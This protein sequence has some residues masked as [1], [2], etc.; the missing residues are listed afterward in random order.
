MGV[1]ETH[2]FGEVALGEFQGRELGAYAIGDL[3]RVREVQ[4]QS[5]TVVSDRG[6]AVAAARR[7]RLQCI[8]EQADGSRLGA[9]L[10]EIAMRGDEGREGVT[11]VQGAEDPLTAREVP[12]LQVEQGD[13]VGGEIRAD[14]RLGQ[15]LQPSPRSDGAWVARVVVIAA[16]P[17]VV[18][19]RGAQM[20]GHQHPEVG[21]VDADVERRF[22][23][24]FAD[25]P[26]G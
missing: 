10:A 6:I 13:A 22:L 26:M 23:G 24:Q 19:I 12:D 4:V 18:V 2:G 8:R 3:L 21:V 14:S 17:K 20:D 1:E 5:G 25:E 11:R 15:G 7:M 16:E 9:A